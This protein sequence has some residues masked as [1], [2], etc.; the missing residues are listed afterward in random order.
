MNVSF[1]LTPLMLVDLLSIV[2]TFLGEMYRPVS[3]FRV[4]LPQR[5]AGDRS[6]D[7]RAAA[8]QV[9]RILRLG[10]LLQQDEF[11]AI[12]AYLLGP[13]VRPPP[14][15]R[16]GFQV[17]LTIFC[18]FFITA[19]ILYAAEPETFA[20]VPN[21]L[22]FTVTSLTTVGYG[23]VVPVTPQGKTTVCFAILVG[24]LLLPYE[25]G[26]LAQALLR[27]MDKANVQCPACG[28]DY[29]EQDAN[30]CRQCGADL[31]QGEEGEGGW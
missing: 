16:I 1:L 5:G 11:A 28:L 2:P 6:P 19:G 20:S 3:L 23:D 4:R 31:L 22:Y 26:V 18:L 27:T 14:Y 15:T 17:L 21:A 30:F 29:H 12:V 9:G 24:V 13:D 10:R 8:A 7:R 25:L